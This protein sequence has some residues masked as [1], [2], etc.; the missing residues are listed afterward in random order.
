MPFGS[1]WS[2]DSLFV[3]S[4]PFGAV[5]HQCLSARS[6]LST[7]LFTEQITTNEPFNRNLI[8]WAFSSI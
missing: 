3:L 4:S 1:E 5:C 7:A 6:G 8:S 2:F